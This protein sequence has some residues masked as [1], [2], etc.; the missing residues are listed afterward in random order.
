[1]DNLN[2]DNNLAGNEQVNPVAPPNQP[3]AGA[4]AAPPQA[5]NFVHRRPQLNRMPAAKCL[6]YLRRYDGKSDSAEFI[7]S[8]EVDA[9]DYDIE[10]SWLIRNFDRILDDDAKAWYT[11]VKPTYIQRL[12]NG[13]DDILELWAELRANFLSFF[14]H[15]SQVAYHRQRDKALKFQL[16]EDPQSYVTAKLE[17]L[18]YID[19]NLSERKKV[20][21]LMEG[22][23]YQLQQSLVLNDIP[24]TNDFVSKLRKSSEL[25]ARYHPKEVRLPIQSD[26]GQNSMY[27]APMLAQTSFTNPQRRENNSQGRVQQQ[28]DNAENDVKCNYCHNVGHMRANCNNRFY[29]ESRQIFKQCRFNRNPNNTF[30]YTNR[31]NN[32]GNSQDPRRLPSNQSSNRN[33]SNFQNPFYYQPNTGQYNPPNVNNNRVQIPQQPNVGQ[34]ISQQGQN[35]P[36]HP[37]NNFIPPVPQQP[38]QNLHGFEL[39]DEFLQNSPISSE[40]QQS[41]N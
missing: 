19:K 28:F 18:R 38:V 23:P 34:N 25:F 16:G 2:N 12:A 27:S 24:N 11:S 1:M 17:V 40:V 26:Y 35:Q 29:D 10:I 5:D 41:G 7:S 20:E 37:Q 22:L 31:N 9:I 14:D 36:Q 39:Q 6:K 3:I 32:Q 21:K 15:R 33:Q 4:A 30:Q 8:L 13:D